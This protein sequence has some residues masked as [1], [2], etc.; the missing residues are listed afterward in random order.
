M[1]KKGRQSMPSSSPLPLLT[2]LMLA[3]L[4]LAFCDHS[5]SDDFARLIHKR[6]ITN[7][8]KLRTLGAEFGWNY[9]NGT[10]STILIDILFGVKLNSPQGWIAWGVNPGKRAEMIG[11]K[12]IIGIKHPDGSLKVDTY[13][14][15]R[16]TQSGCRLLPSPIGIEV[17]IKSMENTDE[18]SKLYILSARLFLPSK[19]YNITKLNHVWQVGHAAEGDQPKMHPTT[20]H[21]V[22]S[23]ETIDLTSSIGT[24]FGQSRSRLRTVRSN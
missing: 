17:P 16:E 4:S 20:L 23:T 10:N 3:F 19:E 24:S 1:I 7:C 5:C 12:A 14:V 13:N 22:D 21:N 11:T 8:K 2:I 9:H 15:T 18:V 6:N